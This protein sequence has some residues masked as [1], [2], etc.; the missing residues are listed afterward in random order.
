VRDGKGQASG[1]SGG[2][3]VFEAGRV[4]PRRV[5]RLSGTIPH[6]FNKIPLGADAHRGD[7]KRFVVHADEK[8][9]AFMEFELAIGRGAKRG[10]RL[11][12]EFPT[13][14][15]NAIGPVGFLRRNTV[16]DNSGN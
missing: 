8:L 16:R 4:I 7:G 2:G 1:G 5:T 15:V 14:R 12:Y 11:N 9:T 10:L 6:L 3:S 13:L